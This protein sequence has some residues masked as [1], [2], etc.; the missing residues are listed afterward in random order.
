MDHDLVADAIAAGTP[1]RGGGMEGK[2]VSAHRGLNNEGVIEDAEGAQ[3]TVALAG[4]ELLEPID[5]DAVTAY[6]LAADAAVV[7]AR[8]PAKATRTRKATS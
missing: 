1:V 6:H 8:T 4:I 5:E 3:V 2:L 7:K